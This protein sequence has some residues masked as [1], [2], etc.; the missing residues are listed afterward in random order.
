MD[1]NYG[2]TIVTN[3]AFTFSNPTTR[4]YGSTTTGAVS[5]TWPY[6]TTTSGY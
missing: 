2:I 4:S 3:S 1:G 6:T 5:F